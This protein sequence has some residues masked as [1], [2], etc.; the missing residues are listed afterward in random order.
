MNS[1]SCL[2][3]QIINGVRP[4]SIVYEDD[5]VMAFLDIYPVVRGHILVVPKTHAALLVD[6]PSEAAAHLLAVGQK[7]DAGLRA[8]GLDCEAISLVL[9]DG[10][11]AGQEVEHVHLHVFPRFYR[12][13]VTSCLDPTARTNP[14]RDRL[15]SDAQKIREGIE[16]IFK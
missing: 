3:C 7:M 1:D 11:A 15:N 10:K 12:D 9:S 14:G 13:G 5:Q 4:A 8:S 6:L 16:K 2:F